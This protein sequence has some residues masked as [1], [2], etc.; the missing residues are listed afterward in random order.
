MKKSINRIITIAALCFFI[1]VCIFVGA[2]IVKSRQSSLQQAGSSL[3]YMSENCADEFS[4]IF[5]NADMMVNDISSIVEETILV[6]QVLAESLQ[7]R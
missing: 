5:D 2:D 7:R 3:S 1:V 4:A 6:S